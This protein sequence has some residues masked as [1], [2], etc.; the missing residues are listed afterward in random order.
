[1]L[2]RAKELY[3]AGRSVF[4][5]GEKMEIVIPDD[6]LISLKLP[7]K[8]LEKELKLELAV[9]LYQR[10]ALSLGKAAKLAGITKRGS[11]R[12]LQRGESQDT[13]QKGT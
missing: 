9:I 2:E 4:I 3:I 5:D 13:T 10:G 8:E 7:R 11:W 1:M 12:S 6:V